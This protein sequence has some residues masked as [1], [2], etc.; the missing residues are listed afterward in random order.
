MFVQEDLSGYA[1]GNLAEASSNNNIIKRGFEFE[2]ERHIKTTW[3]GNLDKT[4]GQ[5]SQQ[6]DGRG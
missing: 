4:A 1:A 2:F 5:R 6:E 3:S